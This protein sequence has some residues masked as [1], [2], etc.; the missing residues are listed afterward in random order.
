MMQMSLCYLTQFEV[1]QDLGNN[2]WNPNSYRFALPP[3]SKDP[4]AVPAPFDRSHPLCLQAFPPSILLD[5]RA[6]GRLHTSPLVYL[7]SDTQHFATPHIPK[8]A[9]AESVPQKNQCRLEHFIVLL[10]K[11]KLANDFQ[12]SAT[13]W[14]C[15]CSSA[16]TSVRLLLLELNGR[17]A[18]MNGQLR[19]RSLVSQCKR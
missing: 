1:L 9:S 2:I 14:M 5:W 7:N 19:M 10:L 8:R 18:L 3:L 6:P 11:I 12:E 17:L 4:R 13:G 16:Y 15:L